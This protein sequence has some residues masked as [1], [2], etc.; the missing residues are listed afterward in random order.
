MKSAFVVVV[1]CDPWD[2]S[3]AAAAIHQKW[4]EEYVEV[5]ESDYARLKREQGHE[6][7]DMDAAALERGTIVREGEGGQTR[8]ANGTVPSLRAADRRQIGWKPSCECR[9]AHVPEVQHADLDTEPARSE[10]PD[11]RSHVE[12]PTV[13]GVV[14]DPFY[15]DS[16]KE[17]ML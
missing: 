17:E 3:P 1:T 13:P 14:L 6:W 2:G 16:G 9:A 10:V 5:G 7:T 11:L 15:L 4:G 8:R 12:S